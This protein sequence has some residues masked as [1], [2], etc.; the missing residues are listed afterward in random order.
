MELNTKKEWI[1]GANCAGF[2]AELMFDSDTEIQKLALRVC[3]MCVVREECL[4][5]ALRE[6]RYETHLRGVRG[7]KTPKQRAKMQNKIPP[8]E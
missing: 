3:Q 1:A 8:T 7:G 6:E 2:D 5:D 4:A